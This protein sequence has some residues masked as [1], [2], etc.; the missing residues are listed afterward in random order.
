[1]T[2]QEQIQQWKDSGETVVFTNGVFDILHV[3]HVDYLTQARALGQRLVVGLN[4][5]ESVSTLGKGPD[6][7][8]NPEGAR[9]R[10]LQ[11]LRAVDL[12]VIFNDHTP[13]DLIKE[14]MPD[15]LVKGGDYSANQT[16]ESAKDYI[17][18]SREVKANG[19]LVVAIPLVQ[20]YSTTNIL[21]KAKNG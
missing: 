15:I 17:V 7:P 2:A 18:G 21:K 4:S 12:V 10:V 5:D 19:G 6:R 9:Q 1:M 13:F 20:G 8:I 14:V 3:G 16:D 11:G